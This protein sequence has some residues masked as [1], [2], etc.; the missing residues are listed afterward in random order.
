MQAT[1]P[2]CERPIDPERERLYKRRYHSSCLPACV[3]CGR[4]VDGGH[5]DRIWREF[6]EDDSGD[7]GYATWTTT[8]ADV[9]E[10]ARSDVARLNRR[11]IWKA[12]HID[13]RYPGQAA[14]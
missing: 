9:L 11:A 13:C 5:C 7:P 14:Q 4:P 2:I 12:Q 8:G 1:C 3:K 10:Q 6:L